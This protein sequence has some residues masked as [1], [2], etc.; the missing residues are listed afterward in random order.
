MDALHEQGCITDPH[1]R[2]ESIYL[3]S[4][5]LRKAKALAAEK[6]GTRA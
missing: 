2:T 1:G 3:T 4:E 6:F 5:G